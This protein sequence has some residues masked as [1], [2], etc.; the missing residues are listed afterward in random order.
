MGPFQSYLL[1]RLDRTV[2]SQHKAAGRRHAR[3]RHRPYRAIHSLSMSHR[4]LQA[5]TVSKGLACIRP[6][7]QRQVHSLKTQLW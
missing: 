1:C 3:L 2:G 4:L 7:H 6:E 5:V